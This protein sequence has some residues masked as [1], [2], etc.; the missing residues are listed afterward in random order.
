M[1]R[2]MGCHW[3]QFASTSLQKIWETPW[4]RF[5][6]FKF[7][8]NCGHRVLNHNYIWTVQYSRDK[9]SYFASRFYTSIKGAGTDDRNLMRLTVSRCEIDLGNIKEAYQRL[10]GESL[11]SAVAVSCRLKFQFEKNN[12]ALAISNTIAINFSFLDRAILQD[13]TKMLYWLW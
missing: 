11:S 3:V 1:R 7:K 10:H 9:A 5:V 6:L 13:L 12:F 8:L 4:H 2:R